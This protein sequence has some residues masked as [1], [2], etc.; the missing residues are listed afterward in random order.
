MW[1]CGQQEEA[2]GK[3]FDFGG[4]GLSSQEEKKAP[5]RWLGARTAEA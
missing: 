2:D 4:T 1:S 3:I 5:R